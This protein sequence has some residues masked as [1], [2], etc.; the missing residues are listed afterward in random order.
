MSRTGI[1]IS[2]TRI[3]CNIEDPSV[4]SISYASESIAIGLFRK[5]LTCSTRE[6]P[7]VDAPPTVSPAPDFQL[8]IPLDKLSPPIILDKLVKSCF[9][10]VF[11]TITS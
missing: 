11:I 9:L 3:I 2:K 10:G 1:R 6:D 8:V 5:T 4:I 7:A